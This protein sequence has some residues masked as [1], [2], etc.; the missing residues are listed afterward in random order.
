MVIGPSSIMCPAVGP[1]FNLKKDAR[2][3]P[4]SNLTIIREVIKKML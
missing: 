4:T 2:Y 3:L 1:L